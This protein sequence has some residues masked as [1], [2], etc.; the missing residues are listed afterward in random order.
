[1][2]I[3]KHDWIILIQLHIIMHSSLAGP[4]R[5]V[6]Q[7]LYRAKIV[8]GGTIFA[9]KIVLPGTILVAKSVLALP[10]VYRVV[11]KGR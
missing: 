11:R 7:K 2:L 5:P 6:T 10:K 3:L 1:M 4:V 8:L 9:A